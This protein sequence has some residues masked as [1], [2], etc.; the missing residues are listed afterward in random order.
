MS[1]Y[2]TCPVEKGTARLIFKIINGHLIFFTQTDEPRETH[3]KNN[4][5]V[6]FK[7]VL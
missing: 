4:A 5:A 2:L 6:K 3:S 1:W 7:R